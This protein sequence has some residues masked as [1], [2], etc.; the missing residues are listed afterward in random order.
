MP[1]ILYYCIIL[2]LSLFKSIIFEYLE[3][4]TSANDSTSQSNNRGLHLFSTSN[5][6]RDIATFTRSY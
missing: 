5:C 6:G 1:L 4:K 3:K 2:F